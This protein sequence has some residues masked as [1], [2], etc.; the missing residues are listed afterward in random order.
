MGESDSDLS[1]DK[2]QHADEPDSDLTRDIDE[3][4]KKKLEI[5][6][7]NL[8]RWYLQF[9][10]LATAFVA[11]GGLVF[12]VIQFSL[13]QGKDRDS[14]E[15]ERQTILENQIR[16]DQKEI[17]KLAEDKNQTLSRTKFLL[18]SLNKLMDE[19]SR[20]GNAGATAESGSPG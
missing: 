18:W 20:Q 1:R 17:L 2:D 11:V 14:R 13:G 5:E 6:I 9:L 10:P 19:S 12:G 8:K 15:R 4:T 16:S 7:K 3:L